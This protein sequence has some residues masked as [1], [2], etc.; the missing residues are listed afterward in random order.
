VALTGSEVE[1]P[2]YYNTY[3]GACIDKIVEGNLRQEHVR[4]VSGNV[5]TGEKISS[6]G[7]LGFYHHQITVIPE[8]DE[9]EFLGWLKPTA[10]KLSFHRALGLLSF[11]NPKKE[12][13][14][15]TNTMGEERAFVQ[16]GI[17]EKVTPMDILPEYLLKAIMAEDYDDMEALGIYEVVEEDLALCEFIDVSKHDIQAILREG[18]NL[19]KATT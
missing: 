13:V 2:K 3:I 10:D 4:C 5:L 6:K 11:L 12:Y 9:Y 16:T 19:I 18:I 7:Y 14:L 17:F 15:S 1:K 8:G